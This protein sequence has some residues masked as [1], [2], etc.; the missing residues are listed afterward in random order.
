[1]EVWVLE[2]AETAAV[3]QQ[4]LELR[5]QLLGLLTLGVAGAVLVEAV[6]AH[7]TLLLTARL[8]AQA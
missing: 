1:L 5:V 4:L 3:M 7:Q 6:L 8:A 2:A